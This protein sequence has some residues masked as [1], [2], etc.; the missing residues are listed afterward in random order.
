MNQTMSN[1]PKAASVTTITLCV[2][3]SPSVP[4]LFHSVGAIA[5]FWQATHF[6]RHPFV[7]KLTCSSHDSFNCCLLALTDVSWLRLFCRRRPNPPSPTLQYPHNDTHRNWLHSTW[8]D[9]RLTVRASSSCCENRFR[10]IIGIIFERNYCYN[11]IMGGPSLPAPC[12]FW[13]CTNQTVESGS[14]FIVALYI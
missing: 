10:I 5:F 12:P 4:T 2:S 7:R 1:V 13:H 11:H 9:S 6:G 14:V 3:W 8:P